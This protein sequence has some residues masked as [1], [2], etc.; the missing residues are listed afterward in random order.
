MAKI[1]VIIEAPNK[2]EKIQHY[3][4]DKYNVQASVGHIMDLPPEKM[5]INLE[6]F[7]PTYAICSGKEKVVATLKKEYEKC[8]KQVLLC[9]RWGYRRVF[10]CLVISTNIKYQKSKTYYI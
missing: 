5:S 3:L 7:E 6:T 9:N 1:L 8:K 2:K 4:T 10:Y